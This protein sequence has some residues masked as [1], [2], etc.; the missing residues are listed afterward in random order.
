MKD[1]S[2]ETG[3]VF[4]I[5]RAAM[6][7]AAAA[8]CVFLTARKAAA[9]VFPEDGGIYEIS[10]TRN[11]DYAVSIMGGSRKMKAYVNLMTWKNKASQKYRFEL[12]K[13]GSFVIRNMKSW[14]VLTAK[15]KND[16]SIVYQYQYKGWRR[17][18]W[19]VK[20]NKDGTVCF[21]NLK[22]KK[23]LT[24]SSSLP[25]Q[26]VRLTTAPAKK[27]KTQKFVLQK[28][29]GRKT[30][31]INYDTIQYHSTEVSGSK[32]SMEWWHMRN[33]SHRVPD[34]ARSEAWLKKYNA[35]Y[36]APKRDKKYIYFTFDC[37]YENGYTS[38]ILDVLKKKKVKACFFV[39]GSYIR[40]NPELVRRM[41]REGHLVGNHTKNHPAMGALSMERIREELV[42]AEKLMKS[43]TGYTMDKIMRPPMGDFSEYSL[44]A[45]DRLGYVTILWSISY[46]DYEPSREPGTSYVINHYKTNSHDRAITLTHT[47]SSS[48]ANAL[49]KVI[50]NLKKE[51]YSFGTLDFLIK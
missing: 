44:A 32:A 1:Y 5:V 50:T 35:Y 30:K 23:A 3:K 26:Y 13:D 47:V 4:R 37:G 25:D 38:K 17:Q 12:Q 41:K 18:R 24:L 21:I 43:T 28:R 29:K 6:L 7:F 45:T 11:T 15:N 42:S 40:D 20:E 8:L 16:N 27:K 39:T 49:E 48:N 19:K 34:G 14:H 2:H 31:T 36:A 51:G 46:L 10:P 22:Y 33:S 9:A